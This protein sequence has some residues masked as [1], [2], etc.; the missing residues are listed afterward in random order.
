MSAPWTI[1]ENQLTTLRGM[2]ID[3]DAAWRADA[4]WGPKIEAEIQKGIE[5]ID[6]DAFSHIYGFLWHGGLWGTYETQGFDERQMF[7]AWR[8]YLK[9]HK[10]QPESQSTPAPNNP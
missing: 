10:V 4:E 2:I 6:G 9:R 3:R 7:R 1:N 8:R 5:N